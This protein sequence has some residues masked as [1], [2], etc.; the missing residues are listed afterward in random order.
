MMPELSFG[1]HFFQDLVETEIFYIALFTDSKNVTFNGKWMDKKKNSLR[2][3]FPESIKY[4]G[5]VRMY[6]VSGISLKV[7]A[8]I[9]SQKVICAQ[10]GD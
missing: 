9:L 5:V 2:T 7:M 8:D 4:E 6:E 3:Y 10:V 1:T